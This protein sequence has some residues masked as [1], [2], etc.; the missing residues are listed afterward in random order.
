M[1]GMGGM[2]AL[3]GEEMAS[4]EGGGE[5]MAPEPEAGA[6]DAG[7]P[8][9]AEADTALLASPGKRDEDVWIKG[10]VKKDAF[11]RPKQRKTD[12]SKGKWYKPVTADMRKRGARKR[13]ELSKGAQETATSSSKR[14]KNLGLSMGARELLGLGSG[15]YEKKNTLVP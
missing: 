6:E 2:E 9:G 4:P 11:G 13:H 1:G 8:P 14:Q 5:E 3:G 12:K 15:V 10:V 7:T